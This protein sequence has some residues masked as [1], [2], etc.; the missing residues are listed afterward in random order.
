MSQRGAEFLI[1]WVE[2]NINPED[3][4][5]EGDK[6]IAEQK[7]EQCLAA[8]QAAGLTRA[9]LEAEV[10]P[11]AGFMNV[12]MSTPP[13]PDLHWASNPSGSTVH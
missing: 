8:A 3:Y 10:G 5:P 7:A 9:E 13:D 4:P 1:D 6:L 2:A 12:R 11:L